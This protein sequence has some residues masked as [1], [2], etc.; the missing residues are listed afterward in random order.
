MASK[1]N[2]DTYISWAHDT[3]DLLHRVQVR[4]E[5]TVHCKDLFVNDCCNR[6]AVETISEGLP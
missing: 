6:K 3:A 2:R 5:A 1:R 4:A